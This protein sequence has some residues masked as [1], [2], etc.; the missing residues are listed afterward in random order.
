MRAGTPSQVGEYTGEYISVPDIPEESKAIIVVG[1]SMVRP[2]GGGI[3]DG[4]YAIFSMQL[5]P[6]HNDIVVVNDEFGDSMLRRLKK[7]QDGSYLL[8]SDNP[9]YPPVT[10]NGAYRVVGVVIETWHR[11]KHR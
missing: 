4:E 5:E 2:D 8:T 1:N 10:P 11:K 6:H 3:V 7:L 9:S